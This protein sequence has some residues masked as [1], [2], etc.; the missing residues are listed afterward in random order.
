MFAVFLSFNESRA[1]E[2]LGVVR[3]PQAENKI[4]SSTNYNSVGN[5]YTTTTTVA[6]SGTISKCQHS[7]I[8]RVAWK[9]VSTVN[10]FSTAL[11]TDYCSHS[12]YASHPYT[13]LQHKAPEAH[14]PLH[15]FLKS[16]NHTSIYI[17]TYAIAV[18]ILNIHLP[19][20]YFES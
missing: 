14:Y 16:S 17:G 6:G 15:I 2:N 9:T 18:T 13:T 20:L 10:A 4:S 1:E 12:I 11:V 7:G 5:Y 8:T 3:M 19:T